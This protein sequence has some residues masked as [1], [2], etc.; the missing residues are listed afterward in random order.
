M[1][2]CREGEGRGGS[3]R[4]KRGGR[5]NGGGRKEEGGGRY[6]CHLIIGNCELFVNKKLFL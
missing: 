6:Q 5:G 4:E 2:G 3:R 1:E